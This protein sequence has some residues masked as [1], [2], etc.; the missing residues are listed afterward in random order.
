M[1]VFL[2]RILFAAV[3]NFEKGMKGRMACNMVIVRGTPKQ[4]LPR[5][6]LLL[7]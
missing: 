3:V 7:M 6:L 2:K 1:A 5:L 4:Q